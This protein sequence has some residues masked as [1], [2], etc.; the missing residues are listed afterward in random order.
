MNIT[1]L[2]IKY[3]NFMLMKREK[4]RKIDM[5]QFQINKIGEAQFQQK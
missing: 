1:M 5:L 2:N 3:L 4:N